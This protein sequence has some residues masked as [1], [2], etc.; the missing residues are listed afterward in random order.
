MDINKMKPKHFQTVVG[1][2]PCFLTFS[3]LSKEKST[4]FYSFNQIQSNHGMFKPTD[5]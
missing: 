2:L 5:S 1:I 3:F 4:R